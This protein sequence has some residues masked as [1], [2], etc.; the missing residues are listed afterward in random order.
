MCDLNWKIRFF[1]KK[2]LGISMMRRTMACERLCVLMTRPIVCSTSKELS[3]D[4]Q[5]SNS[6][7]GRRENQW[8]V[9]L[10]PKRTESI[11]PETTNPD[12]VFALNEIRRPQ[13]P[14]SMLLGELRA[15]LHRWVFRRWY[16]QRP[17]SGCWMMYANNNKILR[18]DNLALDNRSRMNL[19]AEIS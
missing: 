14:F 19:K 18:N 7:R 2:S 5:I 17:S 11:H 4:I 1:I 15:Y 12:V 9:G 8:V 16:V 13:P 3:T 6:R 10:H